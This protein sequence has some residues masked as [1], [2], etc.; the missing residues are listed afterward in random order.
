MKE[1]FFLLFS[2]LL[3]IFLTFCFFEFHSDEK[4]GERTHGSP[5]P[6]P[7]TNESSHFHSSSLGKRKERD[8]VSNF[9]KST[10]YFLVHTLVRTSNPSL[11]HTYFFSLSLP[12]LFHHHSLSHEKSIQSCR[13]EIKSLQLSVTE[14]ESICAIHKQEITHLKK[15]KIQHE[16]ELSH[17]KETN[18]SLTRKLKEC[19]AEGD[20]KALEIRRVTEEKERENTAQIGRLQGTLK[21]TTQQIRRLEG[22]MEEQ[23]R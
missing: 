7:G 6:C 1:I 4:H 2:L 17:S 16:K 14:K 22:M 23:Q 3:H 15:E 21:T 12:I 19:K 11:S 5:L 9:L 10:L 18:Q 8:R 20:R 13:E